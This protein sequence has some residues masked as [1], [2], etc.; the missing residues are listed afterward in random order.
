[1]SKKKMTG[2][3]FKEREINETLAILSKRQG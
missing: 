3:V 1:V 2:K